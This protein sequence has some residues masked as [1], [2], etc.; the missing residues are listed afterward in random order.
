MCFSATIL[1]CCSTKRSVRKR[2]QN[3]ICHQHTHE[4]LSGYPARMCCYYEHLSMV[5]FPVCYN[6]I[7]R[8]NLLDYADMLVREESSKETTTS[9]AYGIVF[10]IVLIMYAITNLYLVSESL[11]SNAGS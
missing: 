10:A 1:F 2:I 7:I 9:R 6:S 3:R 11:V 8:L 5:T 4:Q